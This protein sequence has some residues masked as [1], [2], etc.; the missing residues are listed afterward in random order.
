MSYSAG[1]PAALQPR[2]HTDKR[3]NPVLRLA[4]KLGEWNR[5]RRDV[6]HLRELPDYLLND[7]GIV[8]TDINS[9]FLSKARKSKVD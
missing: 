9:V 7:I 3:P 4:G 6:E 2:A 8:Y 5:R 1:F